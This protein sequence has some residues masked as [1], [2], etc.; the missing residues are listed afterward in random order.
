ML[1]FA[2]LNLYGLAPYGG[3]SGISASQVGNAN[4]TWGTSNKTDIGA[5][6]GFLKDRITLTADYFNNRNNGLV[7][8][9]LL[10]TSMGV[11]GNAIYRNVGDMRNTG[12]EL[13]LNATVVKSNDLRWDVGVNYT[14]QNNKVLSLYQNKDQNVTAGSGA[15]YAILRVGESLNSLYGYRY[16]GVNP[17]NGNPMYYKADGTK[18]QGN[19]TDTK[20]YVVNADGSLGA[21]TTLAGTDQTILGNSLVK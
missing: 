6:F 19:I 10:P 21:A 14:N 7:L 20:Y 15:T 5:D 3:T 9:A 12:I 16:A 4:L 11:P 18:I 2:F 8:Q 17:L 1:M 13:S